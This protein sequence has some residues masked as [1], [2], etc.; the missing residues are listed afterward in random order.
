M[1]RRDRPGPKLDEN[2]FMEM[3]IQAARLLG[4]KCAHFRSVRVQRRDGHTFWQTPVQA[5]GRGFVDLILAHAAKGII[6][7]ELKV[8][9]NTTTAEQDVWIDLLG[10]YV[11]TFVWRPSDWPTITRVLRDGTPGPAEE[12]WAEVRRLQAIIDGR[13]E[14][15]E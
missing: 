9:G 12:A 7:A 4:W 2:T 10:R 5:D 6:A 8:D 13:A 11:P 14:R 15:A 3:V 1:A